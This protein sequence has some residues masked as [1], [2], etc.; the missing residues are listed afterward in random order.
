MI[1]VRFTKIV[2]ALILGI[3]LASLFLG[4]RASAEPA[5]VRYLDEDA[6]FIVLDQVPSDFQDKDRICVF[7]KE[8]LLGACDSIFRWHTQNPLLF[9]PKNLLEQFEVGMTLELK[10][11][12]LKNKDDLDPLGVRVFEENL[13]LKKENQDN[14]ELKAKKI[15]DNKFARGAPPPLEVEGPM[16]EGDDFPEIVI[17]KLKKPRKKRNRD[18]STLAAISKSIR[19]TLRN[20][21]SLSYQ[22]ASVEAAP[23][24]EEIVPRVDYPNPLNGALKFSL[25]AAY[26]ALPLASYQ[27]LKF[28]TITN[29]SLERSSLWTPSQTQLEPAEGFGFDLQ[30]TQK[31]QSFV[32]LGWR[33]HR[34]DSLKSESTFDEFDVDMIAYSRTT[35]AEQLAHGEWGRM[36]YWTDWYFTS[37]ALGADLAYNTL[38][39]DSVVRRQSNGETFV[40]AHA[41]KSFFT[42][43]PSL[44]FATGFEIWGLGIKLGTLFSFPALQFQQ[45]FEGEVT[46]PER[47]KFQGDGQEDLKNSLEQKP[48]VLGVEI[49]LGISYQ[50]Q[51][52]GR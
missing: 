48:N 50:P 51:R 37:F 34:F 1:L 27:S 10:K 42:L 40:L 47:L 26:P 49:I 18:T 45:S 21:D 23:V 6:G 33:S 36:Q 11:A 3:G 8:Q 13:R 44:S 7:A 38:N 41:K 39:F 19:K 35:V 22:F 24:P 25:F 31:M 29:A 9:P 52:S 12:Y 32:N 5:S 14:L 46:M 17:P 16:I 43:A 2:L 28:K 30:I 20:K 4:Y 15:G